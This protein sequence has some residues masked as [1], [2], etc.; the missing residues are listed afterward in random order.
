MKLS[1]KDGEF[2]AK[3]FI[4]AILR[5]REKQNEERTIEKE[6][7]PHSEREISGTT[8]FFKTVRRVVKGDKED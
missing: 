4:E 6:Q 2:L 3:V 7:I 8:A 5:D 1:K